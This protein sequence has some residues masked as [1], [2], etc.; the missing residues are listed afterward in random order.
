MWVPICK[1]ELAS[2]GPRGSLLRAFLAR[3]TTRSAR[4]LKVAEG[5]GT[6]PKVTGVV[7]AIYLTFLRSR[8]PIHCNL[9]HH[10]SDD[11]PFGAAVRVR[12][13]SEV[14]LAQRQR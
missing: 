5:A 6:R 2:G 11:A 14:L 3:G 7:S 9:L 12:S 8:I 1:N 4:S 10:W 13:E